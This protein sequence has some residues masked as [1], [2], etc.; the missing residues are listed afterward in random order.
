MRS[1]AR[2]HGVSGRCG[3]CGQHAAAPPHLVLGRID[4]LVGA[5]VRVHG[6][7]VDVLLDGV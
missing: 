1:E 3:A 2:R 7:L 6:H 4:Q 5:F